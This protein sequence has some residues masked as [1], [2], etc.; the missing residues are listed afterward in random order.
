MAIFHQ[1]YTICGLPTFCSVLFYN[2]SKTSFPVRFNFLL[3]ES[4]A[5]WEW[6]APF[7]PF[8]ST[9]FMGGTIKLSEGSE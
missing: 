5:S 7:L 2:T 9:L 4:E 1:V 3:P 8:G 6:L